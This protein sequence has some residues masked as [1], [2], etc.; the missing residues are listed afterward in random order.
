MLRKIIMQLMKF[1]SL[2]MATDF[3]VQII[4]L[5]EAKSGVDIPNIYS[6]KKATNSMIKIFIFITSVQLQ[7]LI[8]NSPIF[9]RIHQKSNS[10]H[11][12]FVYLFI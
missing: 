2:N 6:Y 10:L 3:S 12:L 11:V 5:N 7:I 1:F 8:Y 9:F 4:S